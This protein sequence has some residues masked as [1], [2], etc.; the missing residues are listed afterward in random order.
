MKTVR[1]LSTLIFLVLFSPIFSQDNSVVPQRTPEQ[2]AVRQ[3]EKIQQELNLTSDQ[4]KTIYEINLRYA[5]ERQISNTRTEAMERMKNKN[6]EIQ[7]ILNAE[8]N[9]KLQTKRYER[10]SPNINQT[11]NRAIPLNSSGFRLPSDTRNNSPVR[12]TIPEM[13]TRSS[14][15]PT[16]PPPV[17]TTPSPTHNPQSIRRTTPAE[18]PQ[19]T[20]PAPTRSATPPAFVPKRTETLPRR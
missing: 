7:Q 17:Q 20:N 18:Q 3:T 14:F 12:V 2:E 1:F 10:T 11:P 16:T 19:R 4:A 15:R 6:V 5:R 9:E 8:Q 13:N